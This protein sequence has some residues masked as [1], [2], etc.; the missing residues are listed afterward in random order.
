MNIGTVYKLFQSDQ[1]ENILYVG[2][3]TMVLRKRFQSH[4]SMAIYHPS[5]LYTYMREH[6]IENFGIQPLHFF[7]GSKFELQK[8]EEFYRIK[9]NPP[10]NTRRCC[11]GLDPAS[12]TYH[13]DRSK[14]YYNQNKH[15]KRAYYLQHRERILERMR[16]KRQTTI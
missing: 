1:P 8:I 15:K 2:S 3:T 9:Y 14:Q 11:I 4:K 16:M 7:V 5:R 6:G 13:K 12:P 10:L